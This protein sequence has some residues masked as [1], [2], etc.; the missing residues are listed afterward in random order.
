MYPLVPFVSFCGVFVLWRLSRDWVWRAK[1]SFWVVILFGTMVPQY[2]ESHR[3]RERAER[4]YSPQIRLATFIEEQ[5]PKDRLL[6][7][8]NIPE[9]WINRKPNSF[10]I[11]SW[12]DV[13]V[14]SS[15]P[16]QFARW[17]QEN[18]VWCVLWFKEEWTQAPKLAPFLAAGT[19][20]K[21]EEVV[22]TPHSK[23]EDYGW[24]FYLRER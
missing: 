20:W 19:Q 6:L 24:I 15:N 21:Q 12:H 1:A 4:L 8:D 18:D 22:L 9:R 5:A 17:I 7:V 10:R 11:I 3:Q 23:E 14:A 2:Q 13:P 16:M